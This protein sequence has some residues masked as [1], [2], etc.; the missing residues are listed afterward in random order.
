MVQV[1]HTQTRLYP[2]R[3]AF[4]GLGGPARHGSWASAAPAAYLISLCCSGWAQKL[5]DSGNPPASASYF[6]FIL[7]FVFVF[8]TEPHSV[9][10]LECSGAISAH[11]NLCLPGSSDSPTLASRVAGTTGSHH[12]AQVIFVFLV[13]TGFHHVGQDGLDLLTWFHHIG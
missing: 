12:H 5:L 9:A 1:Q 7:F 4:L 10:R 13:E 3:I 11:C 8:E 2:P 6:Y